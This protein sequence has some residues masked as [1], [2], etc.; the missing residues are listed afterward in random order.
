MN[1]GRQGEKYLAH[2]LVVKLLAFL[3]DNEIVFWEKEFM[4]EGA[5][6]PNDRYVMVLEI[7]PGN[8]GRCFYYFDT[9][10]LNIKQHISTQANIHFFHTKQEKGGTRHLTTLKRESTS[11]KTLKGKSF[12]R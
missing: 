2:M 11:G 9:N 10:Y 8:R 7:L 3:P 6:F 1:V 12:M 5:M 4:C